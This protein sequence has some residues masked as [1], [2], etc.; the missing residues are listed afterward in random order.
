[1]VDYSKWDDIWI[2][3]DDDEDCHPNI[4]KWA[5]R[6]LKKRMRAE[7]GET[8]NE[9]I[10]KDK[11]N[12][13]NVNKAAD[14]K[15]EDEENPEEYLE[16]NR[17]KIM[18]YANKTNQD[19]ADGYLMANPKIVSQLTEGFLITQAV[20]LAIENRTDPR[21]HLY[22][23]RCLQVHNINV[24][25][26]VAN[27]PG[28]SSVPLF[29][30]QLKNAEKKKEYDMEFEK[31]LLEILERIENRRIERIEEAK[32]KPVAEETMEAAP[33]G[34]GGLDPSVVLNELPENVQN[35]FVSQDK[36]QLIA[37]LRAM[38]EA[39]ANEI[40]QKCIDSGLWNPS[41][42]DEQP[43]QATMVT[44]EETVLAEP[45]PEVPPSNPDLDLNEL[46]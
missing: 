5:W 24:S 41:G 33:L 27:I 35:A 2:S 43:A 45:E 46:D 12:S 1:M 3:S 25:A 38:P 42:A 9:P 30:R 40:I 22:A 34:P 20:D 15:P 26:Q 14:K 10:L 16:Q 13:T 31:Q 36:E 19:A 32:N 28:S 6:R 37:A 29:F 39:E 4:D 23:R 17:E 18:T 21:V 11:W 8:V 44:P 7:K